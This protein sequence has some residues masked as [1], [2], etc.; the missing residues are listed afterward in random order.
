MSQ[1]L[2]CLCEN[3]LVKVSGREMTHRVVKMIGNAWFQKNYRRLFVRWERLAA[4]SEALLDYRH[5]LIVG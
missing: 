1:P 3:R 5:D 4:C 2:K